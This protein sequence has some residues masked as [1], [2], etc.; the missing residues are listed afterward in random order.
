[1]NSRVLCQERIHLPVINPYKNQNII[2]VDNSTDLCAPVEQIYMVLASSENSIADI[3]IT[4]TTSIVYA[5]LTHSIRYN[6]YSLCILKTV[7]QIQ[8]VY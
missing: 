4:T 8:Q 6:K 5:Y 3:D 2:N 1:M 7:H